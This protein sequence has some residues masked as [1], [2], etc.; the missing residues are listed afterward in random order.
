MKPPMLCLLLLF[1]FI[2]FSFQKDKSKVTLHEIKVAAPFNM[3]GISVPDFSKCSKLPITDFGAVP[4]DK[5]KVTRAI[6]RAIDKANEIGGG[7][8]IIPE[9]EWLT[10]KIHLKSN[11]N[12][13]LNKGAVLLFS[14][15]PADY[16]PAVHTTW[17]GMECYN[18][19]PL[20]YVYECKNIAITGEGELKAR[21]DTWRIWFA[22]PRPQAS[23]TYTRT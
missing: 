20:I 15:N 19:S 1:S 14:D 18:Y 8:V 7:I 9:G 4:G 5:E 10:G 2:F 6:A 11:V 16:L 23:S 3:L 22:R 13:H 17:E 12:L 21:M